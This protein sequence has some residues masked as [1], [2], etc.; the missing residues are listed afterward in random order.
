MIATAPTAPLVK[1][2]AVVARVQATPFAMRTAVLTA[3]RVSQARVN[4]ANQTGGNLNKETGVGVVGSSDVKMVLILLLLM[5][6][7]S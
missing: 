5:K 7:R 3:N 2:T 4:H 1:L 6:V